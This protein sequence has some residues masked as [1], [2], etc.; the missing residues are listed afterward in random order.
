MT[1]FL[2]TKVRSEISD[3]T[4]GTKWRLI[5][6]S[7]EHEIE[8]ETVSSRGQELIKY[9]IWSPRSNGSILAVVWIR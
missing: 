5:F 3:R 2:L 8:S 1:A 4:D 9:R 6:G 7:L